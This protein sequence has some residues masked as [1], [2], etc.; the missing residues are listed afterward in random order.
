MATYA[1]LTD[2]QKAEIA[3]I[4]LWRRRLVRSL[5][6]VLRDSEADVVMPRAQEVDALVASLD[7]GE[8]IP[9]AS[10]LGTA[11]ARDLERDR[12]LRVGVV[13]RQMLGLYEQTKA[14]D[15][16]LFVDAIGVDAASGR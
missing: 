1:E 11:G 4:D 16:T 15:P 5:F 3:D 7:A 14:E 8:S 13:L 9:N 2:Q 12:F 6:R 10:S